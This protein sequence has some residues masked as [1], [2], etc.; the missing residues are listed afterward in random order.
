M[1]IPK[2]RHTQIF[3]TKLKILQQA[4]RFVPFDGWSRSCFIESVQ[5]AE[6]SL[7][8]A[9]FVFPKGARDLAIFFHE[10]GDTKMLE[11]LQNENFEDLS[12]SE[13]IAQ[14]VWLRI[15]VIESE[16]HLV[17][18]GIAYFSLPQNFALGTSLIWATAD[19]IWNFFE[20]HSEDYNWYSKR[21]ILSGVIT[22]AL[23]FYIGDESEGNMETKFFIDRQIAKVMS[24]ERYKSYAQN[25]PIMSPVFR[26]ME[27]FIKK[28]SSKI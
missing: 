1:N 6:V 25:N 8:E 14:A 4:S 16:R 17:R 23:F 20:D 15:K 2:N 3:D 27:R 26:I 13:K 10:Y 21:M 5:N 9:Y 22:S 18:R 7:D 12:Y 11:H 28:P 19:K 24:F